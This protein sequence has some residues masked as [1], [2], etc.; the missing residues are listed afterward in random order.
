MASAPADLP[1]GHRLP[2]PN[3]HSH[4]INRRPERKLREGREPTPRVPAILA[5]PTSVQALP[6]PF[7]RVMP[8][9][10]KARPAIW[11]TGSIST[12]TFPYRSRSAC[13]AATQTSGGFHLR[14]SSG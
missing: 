2:G 13:C 1:L 14:N 6:A 11:A 8:R 10:C 5:H 7:I 9:L 3:P 12:A 4:E